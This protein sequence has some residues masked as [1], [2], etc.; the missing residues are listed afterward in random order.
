MF[1]CVRKWFS[2]RTYL[3]DAVCK[4][5]GDLNRLRI[6]Q[7]ETPVQ[8]ATNQSYYSDSNGS[9]PPRCRC[10]GVIVPFPM[11]GR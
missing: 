2:W 8:S 11:A 10:C 4:N 6:P 9:Y 3:I 5:C 1:D 7:G